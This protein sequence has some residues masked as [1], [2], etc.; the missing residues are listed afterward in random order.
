MV[1]STLKNKVFMNYYKGR[2]I[3]RAK[4]KSEP[5]SVYFFTAPLKNT[6]TLNQKSKLDF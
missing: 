2:Y 6:E 4:I 5:L 3:C 1:K